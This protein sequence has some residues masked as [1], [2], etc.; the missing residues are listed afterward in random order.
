MSNLMPEQEALRKTLQGAFDFAHRQA[1][2]L[3]EKYTLDYYPMY[4]F[5]GQ[6]G[7]DRKRWT[8]WCDGFYPGMM[9]IFAEATGDDAWLDKAIAYSTPLVERQYDR[10]VHD[11]GF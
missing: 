10:A 9:F 7:H 6:F 4:T 2:A 8:H 11:L 3:M 1:K 5:A